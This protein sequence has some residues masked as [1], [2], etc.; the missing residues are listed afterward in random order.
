MNMYSAPCRCR[1]MFPFGRLRCLPPR[2]SLCHPASRRRPIPSRLPLAFC[3][4]N[5]LAPPCLAPSGVRRI[6]HARFI[7]GRPRV[8]T[9]LTRVAR[10]GAWLRRTVREVLLASPPACKRLSAQQL[11]QM[12]KIQLLTAGLKQRP[13]GARGSS[14]MLVLERGF[15]LM[16]HMVQ[17]GHRGAISSA[18]RGVLVRRVK[19]RAQVGGKGKGCSEQDKRGWDC[20]QT[21][22][23]QNTA[24]VGVCSRRQHG[25][26]LVGHAGFDRRGTH[27]RARATAA[28]RPCHQACGSG[29]RCSAAGGRHTGGKSSPKRIVKTAQ[30]GK[31]LPGPRTGSSSS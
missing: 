12:P 10:K 1:R 4:Q 7:R 6:W 2:P 30:V 22:S 8:S 5:E 26:R 28:R 27:G 21:A 24:Q 23:C 14:M 19:K 17:L 15:R 3:T 25:D 29:C 31:C 13:P 11:L 16:K 18:A 20:Q 9:L